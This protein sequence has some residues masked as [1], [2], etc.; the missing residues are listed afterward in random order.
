MN[1]SYK[2]Y[3]CEAMHTTDNMVSYCA[4]C[5][6]KKDQEIADLRERLAEEPQDAPPPER[7]R[8]EENHGQDAAGLDNPSAGEPFPRNRKVDFMD[9]NR[10]LSRP[11]CG[12]ERT[13]RHR[14][15]NPRREEDAMKPRRKGL[16]PSCGRKITVKKGV[17]PYAQGRGDVMD[18]RY[19]FAWCPGGQAI[20]SPA[21]KGRTEVGG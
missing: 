13:P 17:G 5:V 4:V 16:C 8:D 11:A 12:N 10:R 1:I 7:R 2:C 19:K 21:D 3:E 18:H 14:R 15:R 6:S 9:P 20:E